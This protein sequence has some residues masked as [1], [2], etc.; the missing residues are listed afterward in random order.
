LPFVD[1][2]IQNQIRCSEIWKE[3]GIYCVA[4]SPKGR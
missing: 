1:F 2:D 3:E 4:F